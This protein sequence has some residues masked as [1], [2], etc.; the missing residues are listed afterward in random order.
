MVALTTTAHA[1]APKAHDPGPRPADGS[2]GDHLDGLS[3]EQ[4]KLFETGRDKFSK[5][6]TVSQDGL[7]PRF[8]LDSC[9]GCHFQPAPGG[10]S[11]S[12][13]PQFQFIQGPDHGDNMLPYFI[14][15]DGP[16]REARFKKTSKGT[17]DGGVHD[18]FT[19]RA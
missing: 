1:K 15:A 5:A 10:S 13:N 16:T 17:P 19:S 2:A 9:L 12:K 8:N 3:P 14:K 4:I 11:P 7:G 6:D 18:L